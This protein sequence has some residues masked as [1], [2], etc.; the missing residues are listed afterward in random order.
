MRS[1]FDSAPAFSSCGVLC[2]VACA[3]A[4]T[5][6]PLAEYPVQKRLY[7]AKM[8][9]VGLAVTRCTAADLLV[10]PLCMVLLLT[11]HAHWQGL[12]MRAGGF[13]LP[14]FGRSLH[15][16]F[17]CSAGDGCLM[18]MSRWLPR[19]TLWGANYFITVLLL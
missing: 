10:G 4:A 14:E 7:E 16:A 9:Q 3:D 13:V 8:D 18:P 12:S 5:D 19:G 2:C 6:D 15:C 17:H 1:A 11:M